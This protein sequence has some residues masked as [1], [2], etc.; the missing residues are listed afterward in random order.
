MKTEVILTNRQKKFYP[1]FLLR[2]FNVCSS[3]LPHF[4]KLKINL[5]L[6]PQSS[7]CLNGS[8]MEVFG[9]Y[10]SESALVDVLILL[11]MPHGIFFCAI[12]PLFNTWHFVFVKGCVYIHKG[13]NLI[14]FISF[15]M[16][17]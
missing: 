5:G 14:C 16:L 3:L 2:E 17:V 9:L 4:M 12:R 7:Q 11:Y 8:V 13:C 6:R 10:Y 15:T 1:S